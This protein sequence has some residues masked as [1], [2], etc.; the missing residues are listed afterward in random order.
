MLPIKNITCLILGM[1]LVACGGV[2]KNDND[3]DNTRSVTLF[4]GNTTYRL[5]YDTAPQNTEE[6]SGGRFYCETLR[7]SNGE[8][9]SS[10]EPQE[11]IEVCGD[12]S[13]P[14][15]TIAELPDSEDEYLL[16]FADESSLRLLLESNEGNLMVAKVSKEDG[17]ET[18][19][20]YLDK[21]E[22]ELRLSELNELL[23]TGNPSGFDGCKL[24]L[25]LERGEST[26]VVEFDI[27]QGELF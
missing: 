3:E 9:F 20:L 15:A 18:W 12:A 25:D 16:S 2:S 5:Y 23:G 10:P 22:A 11:N 17:L 13:E 1:I 6:E 8:I 21:E 24:E 7:F 27:C 26:F 19:H 4:E 14:V